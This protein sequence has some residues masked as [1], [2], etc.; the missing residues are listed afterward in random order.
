MSALP[1]P[2]D[3]AGLDPRYFVFEEIRHASAE[4]FASKR[5]LL[6]QVFAHHYGDHATR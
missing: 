4:I 6:H 3:P 1:D 2:W 5:F